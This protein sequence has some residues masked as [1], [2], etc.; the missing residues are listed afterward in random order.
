MAPR[1]VYARVQSERNWVREMIAHLRAV[2]PARAPRRELAGA[3]R[4][5]IVLLDVAAA[6]AEAFAVG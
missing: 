2:K 3:A 4:I 1:Q 5:E 6:R